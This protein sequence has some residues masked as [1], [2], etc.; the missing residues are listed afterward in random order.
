MTFKV[1][2]SLSY[3]VCYAKALTV[4]QHYRTVVCIFPLNLLKI[5]TQME[6]SYMN[7][8]GYAAIL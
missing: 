4:D 5:E 8:G 7:N 1:K 3:R 6:Q 2:L